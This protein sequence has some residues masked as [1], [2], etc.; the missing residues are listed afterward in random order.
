MSVS[1]AY[2]LYHTYKNVA[3]FS[4]PNAKQRKVNQHMRTYTFS[5][6]SQL[7]VHRAGFARATNTNGL[8]VVIGAIRAN[9]FGN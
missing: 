1:I 7:H 2:D 6:G 5:D 8:V 3:A 4:L 9:A